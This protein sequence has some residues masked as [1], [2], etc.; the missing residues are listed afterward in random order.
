MHEPTMKRLND[1]AHDYFDNI[2]S[3]HKAYILGFIY[4]DGCLVKPEN[5]R[6]GSLRISIQWEDGYIL[7]P[8]LKA[9]CNRVPRKKHAPSSIRAGEKPQ[10][11]LSI[12]SNQIFNRLHELGC[13][14]NK[15]KV[16]MKFP[17]LDKWLIPHFIRGFFD[18]DGCI[19][20]DYPKNKYKRV[21]TY[22]ISNPFTVKARKRIFFVST[23]KKFLEDVIKNIPDLTKSVHWSSKV[24]TLR[25]W[26][27]G[28]ES[29]SNV[30]V[31]QDF[32]YSN[33]TI[34]LKRKFDKFNTTI[35]SEAE[36][37]S[38]ERLETT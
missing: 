15:T 6:Q 18:G 16:G 26:K 28:I 13:V 3:E 37:T 7:E 10:A 12:N 22:I 1:I 29:I 31:M 38:S 36:D 20:V 9:V 24:R 2:D 8:F 19:T 11:N 35:K 23:D 4:A 21:T 32:L 17:E 14:V 34:Y 30:D 33:A 5:G 25:V 27:V